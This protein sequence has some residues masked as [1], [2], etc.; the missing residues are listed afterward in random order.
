MPQICD[1]IGAAAD[2]DWGTAGNWTPAPPG[3]GDSARFRS[4]ALVDGTA[5]DKDVLVGLDQSALALVALVIEQSFTGLVG[6]AVA[7]LQ[8]SAETVDI[9]QASGFGAPTG[10]GRLN[11]HIVHLSL[12]DPVV[13]TIHDS[14]EASTELLL[15]PIRLV[16]DDADSVVEVRRGYVGIG[17]M[18]ETV[19]LSVLRMS[20]I[21][22]RDT[23]ADVFLG[24]GV[25]VATIDKAGGRL[26]SRVGATLITN[27]GG[28]LLTEG[29]GAVATLTVEG[30]NVVSNSTG[31]IAALNLN[32]GF[33]DFTQSR[34][35]RTVT[36][37]T[38]KAGA[39]LRYDPAVVTMTNK[40]AP[41]E[42]VTLTA[43]AA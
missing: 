40:P 41:S 17:A 29:A 23:D 18:G 5:G 2:G 42:A 21:T 6:T 16:L 15:P 32:G 25:A 28:D 26:V 20:Y 22:Q 35:P 27:H 33:T 37:T 7:P 43:S 36:T 12:Q 34:A 13:V 30:G 8:I 4:R 14:A 1:W 24:A 3:A 19:A 38:I 10:S 39:V 9:G 11:L 31:T